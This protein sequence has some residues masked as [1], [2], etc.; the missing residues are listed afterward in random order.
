MDDSVRRYMA[1]IG[2]R[3]GKRSRRHLDPEDARAM[4]KVR[5]PRRAYRRYHV[6]CFWSSDPELEITA[7]HVRWVAAQ[8]KKNGDRAAWTI[9]MKLCR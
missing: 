2:R 6:Q 3:G 4:V 8:L 5:E 7:Q 9:G 1:E